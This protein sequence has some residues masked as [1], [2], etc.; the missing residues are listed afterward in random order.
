MADQSFGNG[1]SIT[2]SA[3][4]GDDGVADPVLRQ[5]ISLGAQ[6]VTAELSRDLILELLMESRLLVAVVAVLDE[7]DE[8]G[9]DKDSHMSVVS[10]VNQNGERGLLAFTGLDS[11]A[12]WDPEARPVPVSGPDCARSALE[13]AADALVI[14]VMGPVRHVV[15]DQRLAFLAQGH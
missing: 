11:M 14:D 12:Q 5:A 8:F 15:S 9:G 4:T 10:M 3:F 6:H 7:R 2:P 13:S 1:R